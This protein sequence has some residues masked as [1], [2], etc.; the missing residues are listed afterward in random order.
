MKN[1][2]KIPHRQIKV[3]PKSLVLVSSQEFGSRIQIKEVKKISKN[4]SFSKN[5]ILLLRTLEVI[6]LEDK[7]I[8]KIIG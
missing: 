6:M 4:L 3:L 2:I 5:I 7:R 1:T 8:S